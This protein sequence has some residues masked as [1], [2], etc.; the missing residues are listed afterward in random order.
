MKKT[1]EETIENLT[2]YDPMTIFEDDIPESPGIYFWFN[3]RLWVSEK[4]IKMEYIGKAVSSKGLKGRIIREHL[5][6]DFLQPISKPLSKEDRFQRENPIFVKGKGYCTDR[7]SL[8]RSIGEIEKKKAD[9]TVT[10]IKENFLLKIMPFPKSVESERERM[11]SRIQKKESEYI[12]Y[13]HPTT[14]NKK[15]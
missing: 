13:Y 10:F 9:Q 11:K 14:Y 3:R 12:R 7:S 8:R 5:R 6:P 2:I 4:K 15:A 1:V